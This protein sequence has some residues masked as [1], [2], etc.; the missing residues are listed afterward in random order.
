[1]LTPGE[2]A[3][4][5]STA[6]PVTILGLR[7]IEGA[8]PY[9]E[10]TPTEVTVRRPVESQANGIFHATETFMIDELESIEDNIRRRARNH[11][12]E[13]SIVD[14]ELKKL[15]KPDIHEAKEIEELLN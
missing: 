6:E 14:E 2:L 15:T 12:N 3:L 11:V 7:P 9:P 8:G 5:K 10:L 13:K 4:I 1:M